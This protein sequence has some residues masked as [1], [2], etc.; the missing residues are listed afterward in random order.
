[1]NRRSLRLSGSA[2]ALVGALLA[3]CSGGSGASPSSSPPAP[4]SAPSGGSSGAG[5]SAPATAAPSI[6][7][8][9]SKPAGDLSKHRGGTLNMIW[10]S[11]GTSIDTAVDYD[12]NWFV[13][14]MAGDGLMS[15]KQ[16][17][18]VAGNDLVPDLATATPVPTDAGKT[19]TFKIRSGIKYSTGA[20][21]KA[22]DFAYTMTR[23]F[24]I[25]GPG[26]GL[27]SGIVGAEGCIA[28]PAGCDLS[29]G[30]VA[31]DA[32]GTVT[33][34]LTAADSDFLQKLA[35]PFAYVVPSGT[36]NVDTGT[37]PLPATGPY[38]IKSYE[39]NRS[40][41]L[42]RNPNFKQWSADA[43]PN[44]YPDAITMKIGI[45]DEDAVTQVENGQADWVYDPPPADRL[46]EIATKYAGQ[47]HINAT[48]NSY[49]MAMNT[50]VAPFD[51]AEVR[52]AL[53]FATDRKAI[54]GLFGGPRLA[55]ASCQILPSNFPGYVPNCPYTANPGATW[56]APDLAKAQ[57]LID[58]SGTKGQKVVVV[59]TPDE[60]TKGIDL[61]FVS[62]LNKLGYDASLKTLAASVEYSY[63]QDSRNKVQL[64]YSYWSPDYT[65]ASNFLNVQV[66]CAGFHEGSTASPNLSAFC[67]PAIQ[68]K[69]AQA[70]VTQQT[71]RKAA[72]AQWAEVDK[73]TTAEAPQV[74]LFT[75]NRLDFVSARVGNYQF[76]PAVTANFLIDQAWVQ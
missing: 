75:S 24:K 31:D 38:L 21:V 12:P 34:H 59:G 74:S 15:W 4:A 42:M 48:P 72:E 25:P 20:T 40:L 14:R 51:N 11:A 9:I 65:A 26:V 46:N 49:F 13:L 66:G 8:P 16:V 28:K 27:Y 57:E 73:L 7:A 64:S 69:T 6:S 1:M 37:K 22:S 60:T 17:G 2:L 3:G 63:V 41:Q 58:K 76:S 18:G 19:Y 10:L 33:F 54:I 61:Y 32:A 62:L 52:R 29:R 67:D 39:P 23:E 36:P 50:R 70:L 44:G 55:N 35:L 47:I 71:D 68:A 45:S 43:Q 56:S 30:V 5:S 53:N